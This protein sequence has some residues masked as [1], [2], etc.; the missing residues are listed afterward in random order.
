[1]SNQGFDTWIVEMRGAGLSIRDYDNSTTSLSG[2]FD[3]T[4]SGTLTLDKSST[5]EIPSVQTSGCSS[6]DYDDLGIVA[7]DDPP[8]LSELASFFDRISKLLDEAGLNKNFHE[9][10]DKISVLSEIVERSVVI[11]PMREESLRILKNFQ[12]QIDSWERFVA[13]Q[14]NLNYEY[15]WDFDHYLEEDIPTVVEYIRQHSRSK[16]GKLFA[17]GHS[18]GGI[19]LYAMLSKSGF[20]GVESSLAAIVT[21]A[22]S[23]DYTTSNSSLKMLLPLVHPAQALNVP[24]VP[25]GTLLAAAYPWASSPPY[26]FSWLNHQISAQDMMHPELLSK[27]V[28]NNFLPAKVVLQLATAFQ[29]GG[30]CNRTG[31]FS[32]KDHLRACQTPALALAGD[33]DLICPPEA[34]YE[35]VK[36]IPQHMVKYKVF[37]KPE[38]P[39]YAHYD[40]V[41]GRLAMDE[42]YPWMATGIIP[43]GERSLSPLDQKFPVPSGIDFPHPRSLSGIQPRDVSTVSGPRFAGSDRPPRDTRLRPTHCRRPRDAAISS[44]SRFSGSGFRH[45]CRNEATRR[46]ADI[47]LGGHTI[48]SHG[49]TVARFHMYDWIILLFLAVVDGL[50]NIIEPFHRFVGRDMMTDL[51]YPLKGN[52]I[53]FWAVPLIAIVLPWV[54]FGGIYFKKKNVYDLHHGIL[55]ILYSVLIT[56]VITDAIKDGVGRPRP[57]FFWRCFPDGKPNFD[58]VTTD[59][60]CHGEKSVIKEGHKS[61][62]SGHSSWSFAGLGFLAWYLAGK[63]QAFDRKGHIAKLCIVFLP[64]LVASLV[65]V[66]RVDDYWHHWQ[67]VFAGGIIGLT[68]ASFCY[69]QFFPCP[70]DADA[71]WPHAHF[72]QLADTQSNGN[73][74]AYNMRPTYTEDV[75]EGHGAIAL[76]DT[77]RILDSMES[78]RRV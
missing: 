12:E 34:V 10:T 40:L 23:V 57:D 39:H 3:D 53:P 38:G 35:T 13:T 41:G 19:L 48:R 54:V 9:I 64:L 20:E 60:I 16:D 4:S 33:K 77:S 51:S 78:G 69:L 55:G 28:F 6:I 32:Y 42:V 1:M 47:Q 68:V 76:R 43:G 74:N 27:L 66:S 44:I 15:N 29:E 58:N 49:T 62:P 14:M 56:A 8:L 59:V 22:S 63:L 24:A 37:G 18:M 73:A 65:A 36:L 26:L 30:L 72:Q 50:L 7:L 17:I 5:L 70:L 25:L 31:T 21:L 46:M 11:G 71:I 2:T 67:D 61:F 75:H 45:H 52:T